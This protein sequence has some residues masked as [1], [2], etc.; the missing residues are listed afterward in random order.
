MKRYMSLCLAVLLVLALMPTMALATTT[1]KVDSVYAL[2]EA[3]QNA[4]DGATIEL[5]ALP[6]N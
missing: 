4:T 1:T 2:A 5:T 3:I 6:S